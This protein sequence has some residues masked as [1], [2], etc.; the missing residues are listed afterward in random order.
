MEGWKEYV[1]EKVDISRNILCVV[2]DKSRR[3][4]LGVPLRR[5]LW[6]TR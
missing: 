5:K 4:T 3:S 1:Y 6:E 2:A